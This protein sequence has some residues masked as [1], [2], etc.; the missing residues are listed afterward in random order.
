MGT[1]KERTDGKVH[2]EVS[3]YVMARRLD[4]AAY[5]ELNGEFPPVMFS[6]KQYLERW[7]KRHQMQISPIKGISIDDAILMSSSAVSHYEC[8]WVRTGA[9]NY[10]KALEAQGETYGLTSNE[11][12]HVDADHIANRQ[13]MADIAK[14]WVVLLP[15]PWQSNRTFGSGFERMFEKIAAGTEQLTFEPLMTLKLFLVEIPL[16]MDQLDAS[17]KDLR[18]QLAEAN[19]A[20][21]QLISELISDFKQLKEV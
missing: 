4:F 9:N 15:V 8:I 12:Q 1:K 14:S 7:G 3:A 18:G 6:E 19:G 16:T 13:R 20:R 21:E 17:I 2:G 5:F 10:R 11:L